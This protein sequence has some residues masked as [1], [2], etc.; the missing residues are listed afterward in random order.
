[1]NNRILR[2]LPIL[3][4]QWFVFFGCAEPVPSNYIWKLPSVDRPGSLELLTWNL[5]YF[6]ETS[7][8]PEID[9][10]ILVLDSLNADIIC[11][12]EIYAM[13]ALERV[14][15]ALPQYELIKSIRTNYL[16]LGILYKPSV[17]TPI[18]TTE[19][20]PSDGNAFASRYPLKVK[21]STSISGQEFEFSVIDIHLKAKGDASSIQRRHNSTTLLHD[22]LLNTIEAGV[23][24][25]FIVMGD[26]NDDVSTS[27]GY[28]S[29]TAFMDDTINF[30]FTTWDLAWS[31]SSA[32]DSYPSW[33]SFIDNILISRALFDENQTAQTQ[34]ILLDN[35]MSDYF[36]VISDHRPVMYRFSPK[37]N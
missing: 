3:V 20:F 8:T 30:K 15:A 34:T 25:N 4:V 18:D 26:W 12:Q 29:F 32:N 19:L 31:S 16:M 22:Y 17:L 33:S 14:T 5:R 28:D 35:Y 7:G 10:T 2:L 13:S 24:T 1:M 21:F 6:G 37:I 27:T 9:R 23:D 11:V 36:G